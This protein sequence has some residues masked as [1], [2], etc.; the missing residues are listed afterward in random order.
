[1]TSESHSCSQ[2]WFRQLWEWDWELCDLWSIYSPEQWGLTGAGVCVCVC[3]CVRVLI[4]D[5]NAQ[6]AVCQQQ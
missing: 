1:M 2:C 3:V 5:A 6:P 4:T